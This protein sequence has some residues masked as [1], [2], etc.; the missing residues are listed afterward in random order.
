MKKIIFPAI[1]ICTAFW[2]GYSQN[3]AMGEKIF[4]TTCSPCHHIGKGKLVGPDLSGVTY[5]RTEKWLGSFIRSSQTMI[6]NNDAAAVKLFNEFNKLVM[7][8]QNL[9]DTQIKDILAYIKANSPAPAIKTQAPS[10]PKE[11]QTTNVAKSAPPPVIEWVH[12][13]HQIKAIRSA[14]GIDPKSLNAD[15]WKNAP[16]KKIPVAAQNVAYPNLHKATV[17]EITV[18]T[19]YRENQLAFL[20]EWNDSSKNTEVDAD[21]FCDQLA[22]QLPVDVNDIP[23]YMMG[24][25]GGKVHIVHWKAIWQEDCEKGFRDVLDLHP[26]M[27]V[28]VYPGLESYLDRSKRIYSQDIHAELIVE[29]SAFGTMPGTYSKNPMSLIKRKVPVEEANAEGFGTLAT[30]ETQSASGW[31]EWREGKWR[32]C[33]I[34][35]VNT[36]NIFKAS[37]KDKT[38]VAFAVWDGGN[39]NIG[40]RKHYTQW[41]DLFIEK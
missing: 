35:P 38:K 31:G 5:R 18:K 39:Q 25:Q 36:G 17:D 10:A 1:I 26:N 23:N 9:S 30:Q 7:P 32:V 29:T 20:I 34:I 37:F 14:E 15:I 12:A 6:K 21:K 19:V 8:D 3:T 24:N 11:K 40:G 16:A 22:V 2:N 33:I 13:E 4:K 28:D 27:W 41:A